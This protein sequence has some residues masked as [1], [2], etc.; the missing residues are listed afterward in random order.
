MEPVHSSTLR[1]VRR[2]RQLEPGR[3]RSTGDC[4]RLRDVGPAS[5]ATLCLPSGRSA[6]WHRPMLLS[7]ADASC[8]SCANASCQ[9]LLSIG[10]CSASTTSADLLFWGYMVTSRASVC[11][12]TIQ[13]SGALR[14]TIPRPRSPQ[15]MSLV[16]TS[17]EFGIEPASKS[18]APGGVWRESKPVGGQN[19]ARRSAESRP[20]ILPRCSNSSGPLGS[21]PQFRQPIRAVRVWS[22]AGRFPRGQAEPT[23]P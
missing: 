22:V 3:A 6:M 18:G 15:R 1:H 16:C 5:R 10:C 17:F 20:A 23:D 4:S 13:K 12:A 2:R 8:L 21:H 9:P 14:R 11:A 19:A 7:R